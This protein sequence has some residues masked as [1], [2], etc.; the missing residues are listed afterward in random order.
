MKRMR[1]VALM[2]L[3]VIGFAM[4]A[5]NPVQWTAKVEM[6]SATEG[7]VVLSATIDEGWHV[8]GV[9]MPEDGPSA[10]KIYYKPQGIEFVGNAKVAPSPKKEKD[11]MFGIE[12]TYWERKVT[13][14]RK[15]KVV[16]AG[17]AAVK[18]TVDFMACNDSNCMPPTTKEFD[19]KIG[20]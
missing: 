11:D 1:I 20:K 10:T 19:L 7:V 13:F 5:A 16:D 2:L 3:A 12:V 9:Q 15:F 4:K 8:Y 14:R 17:K 18:V 6:A